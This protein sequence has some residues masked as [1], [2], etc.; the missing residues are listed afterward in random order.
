MQLIESI[1]LKIVNP[2]II[3]LV[4]VAV[5]VFLYGVYEFIAGAESEEKRATGRRH[6]LWGVVG[7]FIMVSFFGI[8]NLICRTFE[9]TC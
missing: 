8:I 3:L 1:K 2:L 9:I 6:M 5:V 7:L 4:S